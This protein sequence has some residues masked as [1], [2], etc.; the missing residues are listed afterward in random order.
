MRWIVPLL[1]LSA[2]TVPIERLGGL[3]P[4]QCRTFGVAVADAAPVTGQIVS[5]QF[6][7]FTTTEREC[8]GSYGWLYS[9][10]AVPVEG[11]I[12]PSPSH[13]YRIWYADHKCT[14]QHEACHALYERQHHTVQF[15]LEVMQ[16]NRFP[17][18]SSIRT[19]AFSLVP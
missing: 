6:G 11:N 10:C 2:C 15:D 5:S 4:A 9:G 1:L 18:C 19:E 14:P 12:W 17:A 8:Y 13:Q 16:G 7:T 3:T